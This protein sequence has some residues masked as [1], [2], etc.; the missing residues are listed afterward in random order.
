MNMETL[1]T[2]EDTEMK[3]RHYRY[4][5]SNSVHT[6]LS[7]SHINEV[8]AALI[9]SASTSKV[10]AN[11]GIYTLSLVYLQSKNQ[12][13]VTLGEHGSQMIGLPLSIH[14]PKNWQS[15]KPLIWWHVNGTHFLQNLLCTINTDFT[16]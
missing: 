6:L 5:H 12:G 8:T 3:S 13:E 4:L 9:H 10:V 11:G 14:F 16:S 15:R 2:N 1:L 7:M